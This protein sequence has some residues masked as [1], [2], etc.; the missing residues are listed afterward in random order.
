MVYFAA[1]GL[2]T[3]ARVNVVQLSVKLAG[4]AIA[5]PLAVSA[6]GGWAAVAQVRADDP[7]YWTF[8]R[9]G[10]PGVMYLALLTPSFIISPGLL[11]KV[12]GA[13]DDRAVARRAGSVPHEMLADVALTS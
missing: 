11:Q 10:P 8:W 5:L 3:S 7:T 13:R 2:M 9:S 4:F 12:F 1:G 6:A